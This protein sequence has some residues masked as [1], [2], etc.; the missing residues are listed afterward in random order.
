[1]P[2]Q[3]I[4]WFKIFVHEINKTT[5]LVHTLFP[6][7]TYLKGF[8]FFL[9]KCFPQFLFAQIPFFHIFFSYAFFFTGCPSSSGIVSAFFTPCT[10]TPGG[11][12]GRAGHAGPPGDG[13]QRGPDHCCVVP[14][15]HSGG[16]GGGVPH[17]VGFLLRPQTDWIS[18]N[19][20]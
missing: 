7:L 6:V 11:G 18:T 17:W 4:A 12:R 13:G 19:A 8:A 2:S 14:P 5:L 9:S 15:S 1:M 10:P 16:V 20:Q 3:T